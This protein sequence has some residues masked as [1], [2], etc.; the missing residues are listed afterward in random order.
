MIYFN[1]KNTKISYTDSGEGNT[2][3]LL[4]GFLENKKMWQHFTPALAKNNR[5]VTVDLLGHGQS[6]CLGYV[7]TM[8]LQAEMVFALLAHLNIKKVS[9]VGHSMGG[10]VA[11]AFAEMYPDA[12]QNLVLLNST[13]AAD[14]VERQIGRASCRERVYCVV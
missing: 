2:L 13:P 7:H 12:I 10:Y 6:D 9:S 11:L 1:F 3:I 5:V 8:E 4:H 14:S